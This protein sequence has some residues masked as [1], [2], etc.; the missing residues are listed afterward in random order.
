MDRSEVSA[1]G[2]SARK[3]GREVSTG[4]SASLYP[5]V[6]P[7]RVQK[8]QTRDT[9]LTK[10]EVESLNNKKKELIYFVLF[11]FAY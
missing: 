2:W 10:A 4:F 9:V 11:W 3:R 5:P 8:R 6:I 7:A 1:A